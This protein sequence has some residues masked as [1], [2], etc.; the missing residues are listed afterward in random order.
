MKA[1]VAYASRHVQRRES[2]SNCDRLRTNEI[3]ADAIEVGEVSTLRGCDG[4]VVGSAAHMYRWLR[5]ATKFVRRN[6]K[7]LAKRPL[8]LFSSGQVGTDLVD[9]K[10]RDIFDT[11]R[12]NELAGSR[13]HS[14]PETPRSSL[15]LGS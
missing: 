1:L 3:E 8:W 15:E 2:P 7:T 12:P 6:R 4:F 14:L 9:D 5:E 10:G 13:R 11:S